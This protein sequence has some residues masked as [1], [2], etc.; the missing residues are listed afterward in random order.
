MP[1]R[2]I[3]RA[4]PEPRQHLDGGFGGNPDSPSKKRKHLVELVRTSRYNGFAKEEPS[5]TR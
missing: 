4:I 5:S 2:I 3:C 1:E